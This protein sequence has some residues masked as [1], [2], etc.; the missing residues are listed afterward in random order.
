MIDY[1][2]IVEFLRDFRAAPGQTVTDEVRRDAADYAQLCAQANDRLRQCSALLQQ[3]LRSE[4]IHLANETPNLLELVAAL[5]LPD[6]ASWG[7]FCQHN[8]LP[9]APPL[10]M[11]RASQLNDAYGQE[12]PLDGLLRRHRRLALS[13]APTKDRLET[14]RQ[15]REI[16]SGSAFWEK[17]IRDFEFA[18]MRELRIAFA[19]ALEHHDAQAVT[20]LSAEVLASPWLEPVGKDLLAAAQGA[21]ERLRNM[22]TDASLRGLLA[23]LR[24]AFAAREHATCALLVHQV[25]QL[26]ADAKQ[27]V[28]EQTA[29]ELNPIIAWI[30]QEDELAN[31][32][33]AIDKAKKHLTEALDAGS[34][35]PTIGACYQKLRELGAPIPPE[36]DERRQQTLQGLVKAAQRRYRLMLATIAGVVVILLLGAYLYSRFDLASGW[37]KKIHEANVARNLTLA[38]QLIGEQERR[39]PEFSQS[40]NVVAAKQQTS[41]LQKD[42]ERD[43]PLYQT[44]LNALAQQQQRSAADLARAPSLQ[45][46]ELL[47]TVHGDDQSIEQAQAGKQLAWVAAGNKLAADIAALQQQSRQLRDAADRKA[48]AQVR[49]LSEQFDRVSVDPATHSTKEAATALDAIGNEVSPLAKAI[50]LGKDA[51]DAVAGVTAKLEEK[52][53]ALNKEL[54]QNQQ[55]LALRGRAVSAQGWQ[56]EL[57]A[58]ITR[59]PAA[60]P[61]KEFGRAI[62][63]LPG[64]AA[65]EALHN[66]Q[67]GWANQF[68]PT[69]EAMARKRL[70]ELQAYTTANPRSPYLGAVKGYAQY[71]TQGADA[72]AVKSTWFQGFRELLTTPMMADLKYVAVSDGTRYYVLGEFKPW[73]S[74]LNG[75]LSVSFEAVDPADLTKRRSITVLPPLT[76]VTEKPLPVPQAKFIETLNAQLKQVSADNWDSFGIPVVE[77]LLKDKEMDVVV[78]SIL[79]QQTLHTSVQVAGWGFGGIYDQAIRDFARHEVENIVWYDPQKP[80]PQP[81]L[82][83]L[84]HIADA[85]PKSDVALQTLRDNRV[86]LFK[87]VACSF[88]T[89]GALLRDENGNWSIYPC[90]TVEEGS[91][92]WAAGP[93][94]KAADQPASLLRV[95]RYIKGKYALDSAVVGSL[96]EGTM[97]FIGK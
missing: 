94:P 15:L 27:G 7:E 39:A 17:D 97:V 4:A 10:Q 95:A 96:P 12:E 48:L 75:R 71:L 55:L 41:Q 76:L 38:Q 2:R 45:V 58:F 40:A 53:A 84:Q 36:L 28:S 20:I 59:F 70:E 21:D 66:L 57:D 74:R 64:S 14:M 33:D 51:A 3:G 54:D 65:I 86:K 79:L 8:D 34:P 19:A 16:D 49:T 90:G 47:A 32:H 9:V 77:Q 25:R 78:R 63:L 29:A 35:E 93:L 83:A 5:D 22:T 42:Y 43:Y 11:E 61:S 50:G 73:T 30:A 72:L 68:V 6:A 91:S 46:D 69:S 82:D 44:L 1:Q 80:V 23:R 56:K 26:L 52:R 24:S 60:A 92:V 88:A 62:D 87:A 67:D 13:H 85:I 37:A 31:R 81:T 18:R 89:T